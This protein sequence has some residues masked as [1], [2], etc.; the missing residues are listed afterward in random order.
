ME[1]RRLVVLI[2][3]KVQKGGFRSFLKKQALMRGI[4]GYAENLSSNEVLAV[5]EGDAE[6]IKELLELIK[7]EAPTYI[8]VRHITR[9]EEEYTGSFKDFERKGSDILPELE[10]KSSREILL[11][12]ASTL[13]STDAKLEVGVERLGEISHKQDLA[14]EKMDLMLEK[15]DKTIEVIREESKKTRQTVREESQKTREE[16]SGVIREESQKTRKEITGVIK[17][18]SQ[19]TRD[20]L[21]GAIKDESEKTREVIKDESQKT[22]GEL[23]SKL[24]EGFTGLKEEHIKTRKLSKEIFYAEVRE[25]REE[26]RDLRTTV[27]EIRR[28]IEA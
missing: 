10:E 21:S 28:K 26:I 14:L 20:E 1:K 13:K 12:M 8:E 11:T 6:R 27:E 19:K 17:D 25:L 15:Q 23:T 16:L 22:R 3:G 5:M 9:R 2:E 18:E 7:K 4:T 24:D